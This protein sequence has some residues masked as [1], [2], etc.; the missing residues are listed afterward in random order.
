MFFRRLLA[1]LTAVGVLS[2]SGIHAQNARP[3]AQVQGLKGEFLTGKERLGQ[4]WTDEQ[5][6]D[7][8]NVPIDKRGA[9]L[10]SADCSHL[11]SS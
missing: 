3:A 1:L 11:P 2:T 5:R 7:N 8:C 4:K 9:K 10:R 6:I